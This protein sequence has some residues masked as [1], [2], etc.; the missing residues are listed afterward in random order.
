MKER[1]D[2]P[3]N[4]TQDLRGLH[5]SDFV[6][7]EAVTKFVEVDYPIGRPHALHYQIDLHIAHRRRLGP[8]GLLHCE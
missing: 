1:I 4:G 7:E 3:L 6:G 5:H 8:A 2:E